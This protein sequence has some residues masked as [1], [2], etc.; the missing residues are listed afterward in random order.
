METPILFLGL[1]SVLMPSGTPG[2]FPGFALPAF[3]FDHFDLPG[4]SDL[5]HRFD[6]GLSGLYLYTAM[7][8]VFKL[9]LVPRTNMSGREQ[10]RTATVSKLFRNFVVPGC[11]LTQ[12]V[13]EPVFATS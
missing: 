2:L 11:L 4:C 3:A 8:P 6:L 12:S 13:L 5:L 10:A 1:V 7:P 9:R